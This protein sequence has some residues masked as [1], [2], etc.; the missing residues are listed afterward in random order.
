VSTP[1]KLESDGF[2][3]RR[4]AMLRASRLK[5]RGLQASH[6]S[7]IVI[8]ALAGGLPA[9]IV[10]MSFLWLGG[11]SAKIEWT[12]SAIVLGFWLG[13]SFALRSRV[14]RPLQTISNL[15]AALREGDFSIRARGYD[16]AD[17]LGDLMAEINALGATLQEQRLGA[18][19][20]TALLGKVVEEIDV[21]V[22]AF[23]RNRSLRL[24]NRA[25]ERLL[26]QPAD[27]LVGRGAADLG[28]EGFLEG[29]GAS[30]L[31]VSF[32]GGSGRWEY[33]RTT[34]RQDG[35]PHQLLVLSDL[36]RALREEER[37]VWKRLIRVLGHELNNSLAPIRS[38]A[39]SLDRLLTRNPRPDDWEEDM[40]RGLT[41]IGNRGEALS[42][43]M[44]GYSRLSH[45]PPPQRQPL[46]VSTWIRRAAGLETRLA[47]G[48]VEGPELVIQADGDQLD[49]L[50]I[51][52]LRNGVD[53]AMANRGSVHVGWTRMAGQLEVWVEDEGPGLPN[54][55]NLFVPFFTTKPNGSG[56]GLV[57]SRQIAEAHGGS[58]TLANRADRPGCRALL[59][60][61]IQPIR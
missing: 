40:H 23:D 20:A 55:G 9:V 33:R 11:Y 41:I 48:V 24:V 2:L 18:V 29:E 31:E 21:A 57:L 46:D 36:T 47:I 59:R 5:Q 37:Q 14:I 3:A 45:L 8:L 44:E 51:N 54:T 22:F 19:E 7:R 49:Q 60:L 56:I 16:R 61:P 42:R 25:G 50:L 17:T 26:S 53:A 58:L 12:L 6:D 32:P 38:I 13:C 15:L 27:R 52:L 4:Y 34:F 35:L 39:A 28:L 43:F 30:L 10:A 1:R